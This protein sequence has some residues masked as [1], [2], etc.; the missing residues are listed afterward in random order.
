MAEDLK[1]IISDAIPKNPKIIGIYDEDED[2]WTRLSE[3]EK[4]ELFGLKISEIWPF[5]RESVVQLIAV[6]RANKIVE[7]KVSF[8]LMVNGNRVRFSIKLGED[9]E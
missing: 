1:K 3:E 6:N 4:T 2:T 9:S 8:D 5:V 7:K